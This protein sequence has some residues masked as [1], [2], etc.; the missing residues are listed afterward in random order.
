[1]YPVEMGLGN[2]NDHM[3]TVGHSR[4]G[5][6]TLRPSSS[7]WRVGVPG[8]Q[9]CLWLVP[10]VGGISFLFVGFFVFYFRMQEVETSLLQD[11]RKGRS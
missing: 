10:L 9:H 3:K 4:A 7:R 5:Q 2:L 1:M 6:G 11:G 8:Q